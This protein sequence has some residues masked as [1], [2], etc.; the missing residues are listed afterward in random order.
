MLRSPVRPVLLAVL[1]GGALPTFAVAQQPGDLATVEHKDIGR[2]RART[3]TY[4]QAL[5]VISELTR[6]SLA[7]TVECNGVCY[8]PNVS[9]AIAWKCN[10]K[11]ACSLNCTDNPPVGGC[12]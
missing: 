9:R 3:Q 11:K 7:Q 1:L 10:P 4:P 5:G 12:N 8:F 2:L 6:S